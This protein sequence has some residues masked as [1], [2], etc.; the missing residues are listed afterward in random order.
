MSAALLLLLAY[1][2]G[3]IPTAYWVGKGIHGL[4]LRNEG[5]GNL[6]ATNA[7]RVLG[8]K[9]AVPVF[10]VD[11]AKGWVPVRVF[12]ALL[13]GGEATF[14]PAL[15]AILFGSMAIAGHVFSVW[16]RFKG[17]KGVATS[18]GVFMALAPLPL[19]AGFV[20]WIMALGFSRMVSLASILAAAFL[21]LAM[22]LL[23]H[24]SGRVGLVFTLMLSV[25]VIW[26]H[27]ENLRRLRAGTE[28]RIGPR[29]AKGNPTRTSE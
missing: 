14:D 13:A 16:V 21:P 24:D 7:F 3:S 29:R 8:W 25:F 4:D 1:L 22:A 18:A 10:L 26:A 2:L 6:G 12:P 17:G 15:W 9:S 19:L 28:R 5:S 11:V 23:P 20:V 27:R